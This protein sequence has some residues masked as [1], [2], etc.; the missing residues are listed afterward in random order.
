[1]TLSEGTSE[2]TAVAD[3]LVLTVLVALIVTVLA[4]VIE[5]GAV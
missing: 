5:A 1:V 2:T 4:V 3:W